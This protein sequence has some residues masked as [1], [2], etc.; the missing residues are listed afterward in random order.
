MSEHPQKSSRSGSRRQSVLGC[1]LDPRSAEIIVYVKAVP[2][3]AQ[4]SATISGRNVAAFSE[5]TVIRANMGIEKLKRERSRG[6]LAATS[7]MSWLDRIK[8]HGSPHAQAFEVSQA[9]VAWG[10]VADGIAQSLHSILEVMPAVALVLDA[11]GNIAWANGRATRVLG[12]AL[13]EMMGMPVEAVLVP[14]RSDE[15]PISFAAVKPAEGQ[16]HSVTRVAVARTKNGASLAAHVTASAS[17][18]M[19]PAARIVV[20][21]EPVADD[22]VGTAPDNEQRRLH[23]E[24]VSEIGDM[25][26]ALAHEVDQPLTAILS[27]A[28]AAQRFLAQNPPAMGDLCELLG[29]VVSDST[30]AHAIIRKMRQPARSEA[31]E[32]SPVDVG[33]LVRDVIRQLRRETQACGAAV[34]ARI[35]DGLPQLR[36]D[37]VQLQQVLV[38]LLL[39]ALDAVHDCRAQ[40]RRVCVAVSAAADR[41]KVCLDVR[42]S[43]PGV[44]AEQFGTLFKPFVTSKP[45]GLGLGLSISRTIIMAHGGQLW[46]ERNA[47]RGMTFH[48]ELPAESAAVQTAARL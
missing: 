32:M 8:T 45:Q 39:N 14:S 2:F 10:H 46:A 42:D 11:A 48:I 16:L 18:A 1:N 19:G 28:Q 34:G 17:L 21:I 44:D 27:N 4:A 9:G 25:A 5:N 7:L 43:G 23:R 37:A 40:D 13:G 22:A 26:A 3:G 47:D 20:V 15:R 38:N 36:G 30:R 6:G 12:Y 31:G 35:E 29:E 33:S 41:G 24:R